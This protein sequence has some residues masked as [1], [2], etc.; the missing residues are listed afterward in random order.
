MIPIPRED[1][2]KMRGGAGKQFSDTVLD[3]LIEMKKLPHEVFGYEK[4]TEY[5]FW[6]FEIRKVEKV[7]GMPLPNFISMV[8]RM[9]EQAKELE[10]EM[11]WHK[12]SL[13]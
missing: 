9:Q 3:F 7:P 4:V 2:L 6:K 11:K 13:R 10:R 5:S 12:R 8:K 1:L